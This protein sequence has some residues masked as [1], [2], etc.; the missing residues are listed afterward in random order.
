MS[1]TIAIPI[2]LKIIDEVIP[3]MNEAKQSD[4][5]KILQD[6]KIRLLNSWF[7]R[8]YGIFVKPEV[9]TK[10]IDTELEHFVAVILGT[11]G[12]SWDS[13]E[14]Q[15]RHDICYKF[16]YHFLGLKQMQERA[17]F[18]QQNA[19]FGVK[20]EYSEVI[21]LADSEYRTIQHAKTFI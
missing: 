17:L 8:F 12:A 21:E 5:A 19:E 1:V 3:K 11:R 16:D 9:V 15:Y 7:Y 6:K 10:K 2:L 18:I 14:M 20:A 13:D 4:I